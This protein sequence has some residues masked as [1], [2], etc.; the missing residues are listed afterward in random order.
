MAGTPNP[1]SLADTNR[2]ENSMIEIG[3]IDM[4]KERV[5]VTLSLPQTRIIVV[6]VKQL[7]LLLA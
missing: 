5:N 7:S 2:L 3:F 1:F 4:Q 6:S